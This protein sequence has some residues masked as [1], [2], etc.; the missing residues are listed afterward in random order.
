M[1]KLFILGIILM[2][3][4]NIYGQSY[5]SKSTHTLLEEKFVYD[6]SWA[7]FHL[8]TITI[9]VEHVI[10]NP[11]LRKITVDIKTNPYL[12]FIDIDEH[13]EVIMR[14]RDGMTMHYYGIEEL[15]GEKVEINCAYYED[16]NLSVYEVKNFES[17]KLVRKDTLTFAKPYLVGTSLIHYTRLIA[18]SGLVK[19]I[20]TMLAGNFYNTILN[21]CGPIEYIEI[22][23]F[24]EPIRTFRYE[25]SAD[26]D[27]K[28]TAGLSGEFTGWLSDDDGSVV[29][30]AE[31][32]IFLGSVCIE[33]EEWYKPGWIPPTK[34]KLLTNNN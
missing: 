6:V 25:G 31:L 1:K 30:S 11:E 34:T 5:N 2:V 8:G 26:W 10:P 20:S 3:V 14:V 22:D 27:G 7:F 9:T 24:D 17:S 23:E 21:F 32:K 15:D 28:A 19:T 4:L 18:D 16:E 12:P 13:N 33:L 29:I